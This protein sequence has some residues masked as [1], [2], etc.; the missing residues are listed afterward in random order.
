MQKTGNIIV[1]Y[2]YYLLLLV[3]YFIE[4]IV[5]RRNNLYQVNTQLFLL[6][7]NSQFVDNMHTLWLGINRPNFTCLS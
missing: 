5:M 1:C 4:E 3:V 7:F 2:Y 6:I